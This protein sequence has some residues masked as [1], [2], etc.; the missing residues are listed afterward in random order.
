M[1][2]VAWLVSCI[3]KWNIIC[4]FLVKDPV[5]FNDCIENIYEHFKDYIGEKRFLIVIEGMPCKKKYLF[6]KKLNDNNLYFGKR[7]ILKLNNS[8]VEILNQLSKDSLMPL[9]D[10]AQNTKLSYETVKAYIKKMQDDKLI[11]AFTIKLNPFA[12]GYEWYAVLIELD[13]FTKEEKKKLINLINACPNSVFISNMIGMYNVV[14]D[15]HVKD[16]LEL[17]Q[18]MRGI[19]EKSGIIKIYEP[20]LMLKEQKCIFIPQDLMS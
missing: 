8:E 9:V 20:L 10:I 4:S 14:V 18:I 7:E 6:P 15:F 17:N 13:K 3:G 2:E 1:K 19:Q 11:Q 12:Y 16:L 5:A